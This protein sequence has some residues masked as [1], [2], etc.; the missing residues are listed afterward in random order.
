MNYS[1]ANESDLFLQSD[2]HWYFFII[3]FS[4][5]TKT[6]LTLI[7]HATKRPI[8]IMRFRKIFPIYSYNNRVL[9]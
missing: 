4:I 3:F 7:R 9:S 6:H 5:E 1:S 2:I 8:R